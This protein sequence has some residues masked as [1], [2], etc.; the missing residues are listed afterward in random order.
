VSQSLEKI[1]LLDRPNFTTESDVELSGLSKYINILSIGWEP[2][3]VLNVKHDARRFNA[4]PMSRY[5][6][7]PRNW[8]FFGWCSKEQQHRVEHVTEMDVEFN[9]LSNDNTSIFG[10]WEP[11]AL[12]SV[13]GDA[14][15]NGG[16]NDVF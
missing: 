3:K 6:K 1:F 15:K 11:A 16:K 13:K 4:F 14:T 7:Y 2:A 12:F 5:S 10:G 8:S 9:Y